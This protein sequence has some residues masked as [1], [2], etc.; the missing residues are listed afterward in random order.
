[1]EDENWALAMAAAEQHAV[2]D[3]SARPVAA[4]ASALGVLH[5]QRRLRWSWLLGLGVPVIVIAATWF[6]YGQVTTWM[7]SQQAAVNAQKRVADEALAA[8]E[9][10]RAEALEAMAAQREQTRLQLESAEQQE[11][12]NAA[13]RAAD[14]QRA[15]EARLAKER[16]AAE[17]RASRAT[18]QAREEAALRDARQAAALQRQQRDAL[19]DKTMQA[20]AENDVVAAQTAFEQA[21][22]LGAQT[23]RVEAVAL[24]L[25]AA[26][27]NARKPVSDAEFESTVARFHQLKQAIEQGDSA[28]VEQLTQGDAELNLFQGLIENFKEIEISISGIRVRNV[29]KSIVGILRIERM[30]RENGNRTVP[31]PSYRDR[32]ILSRRVKGEWSVIIW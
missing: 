25:A 11:K 2:R 5:K 24:E 6:I 17:N 32:K 4:P 18:Q 23:E 8:A 27:E 29:D 20:L 3:N 21:K 7:D 26:E 16:L 19:L 12:R 9:S 31:G 15:E 28:K 22:G 1:M 30:L 14:E 13:R 10:A